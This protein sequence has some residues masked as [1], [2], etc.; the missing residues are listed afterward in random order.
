[1]KIVKNIEMKCFEN[2]GFILSL[3]LWRIWILLIIVLF[4]I[5]NRT[6]SWY[7]PEILPLPH[8][9]QNTKVH[10]QRFQHF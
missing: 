1:M 10:G 6:Y 7:D 5:K 8:F 2:E 4:G 3:I 9:P